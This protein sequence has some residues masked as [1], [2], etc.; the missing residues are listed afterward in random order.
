MDGNKRKER[1]EEGGEGGISKDW[2]LIR[3]GG[4]VGGVNDASKKSRTG[5]TPQVKG[6]KEQQYQEVDYED[7]DDLD[8]IGL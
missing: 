8:N 4:E 7:D 2:T 1:E 6:G 5:E 3:E